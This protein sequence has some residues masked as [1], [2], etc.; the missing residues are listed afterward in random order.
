MNR[1]YV[2]VAI[3]LLALVGCRSETST[4]TSGIRPTVNDQATR[5]TLFEQTIDNLNHAEEFET[6]E[7][8]H[9]IV[10]RLNQW[11]G[12]QK[13]DAKWQLDPLAEPLM[14][15]L[16][17]YA[18][19]ARAVSIAM[20]KPRNDLELRGLAAELQ[21]PMQALG[22]LVQ[23]RP[24]DE[25][26]GLEREFSD[27]FSRVEQ[28]MK[29]FS[30][31][32]QLKQAETQ[33]IDD[34]A[35]ELKERAKIERFQGALML[36]QPLDYP[37]RFRDA[38]AINSLA[39]QVAAVAGQ[40]DAQ[41]REQ[42][43]AKF[44]DL[45]GRRLGSQVKTKTALQLEF[46]V[47]LMRESDKLKDL[48]ELRAITARLESLAQQLR[49]AAQRTGRKDLLELLPPFES[50]RKK[51]DLE[52]LGS[53]VGKILAI[54]QPEG[55]GNLKSYGVE[56]YEPAKK[57]GEI[58]SGMQQYAKKAD[59]QALAALG[60]KIEKLSERMQELGREMEAPQASDEPKKQQARVQNQLV[61][62]VAAITEIEFL[63]DRLASFTAL[64]SLE[65]TFSD[66]L[67]LQEAVILRDL[68]QWTRG[69][70][71]GDVAY[72]GRL[73]DWTVRNIQPDD[74]GGNR[75]MQLSMETLLLGRGTA[76]DRTWIFLLLARQQ[77]LDAAVLAIADP[78]DPLH[79]RVLPWAIGVLSE[80]EI[81]LFDPGLGIPIPGPD[82]V[83]LGKSGALE[84]R[85]ATLAQVIADDSLLRKLDRTGRPYPV[86]AKQLERVVALVEA[87]P[88]YLA[89]RMDVLEA[90]LV[91]DQ[92]MVLSASPSELAG[93]LKQ[94]KQVSD[95]RLWTMP[96]EALLQRATI[97]PQIAQWQSAMMAPFQ[98]PS[99]VRKPSGKQAS[100]EP[101]ALLFIQDEQ[102]M[103]QATGGHTLK[104]E[105]AEPSS[106][107]PL[108]RGRT[109]HL[110]G[111]FTAEPG[112]P[113]AT[114]AYLEARP[115]DRRLNEFGELAKKSGQA[116]LVALYQAARQDASYWLGLMAYEQNS[117]ASATD[118]L[119]KYTLKAYPNG[120]WTPGATYNLARVYEAEKNY[121]EA[122]KLYRQKIALAAY[123][124]GELRSK[125]LAELAKIDLPEEKPE[126]KPKAEKPDADLP[127]LPSLPALPG[128]SEKKQ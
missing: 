82:G 27:M 90:G 31:A 115:S 61:Q 41:E 120:P 5:D 111:R 50:A 45:V 123:P 88:S 122:I 54:A 119:A 103:K 97:G 94:C 60:G 101:V 89:R 100:E 56:L 69:D 98:T 3:L 48:A 8:L 30:D 110:K 37:A 39:Q 118:Y 9:Q 58:A 34:F 102:Q 49:N 75:P 124:G 105:E 11:I 109:M 42:M 93:R 59:F 55:I 116:G 77:G 38:A 52:Q 32:D 87:S 57:L 76:M 70:E 16:S 21:G 14:K 114:R 106:V 51:L 7:M 12:G 36:I 79:E 71:P 67:A 33:L 63:A 74:E 35:T 24:L 81:Y 125:W 1:I 113:S 92:Q 91:G 17:S 65:F 28:S 126:P 29:L 2:V 53:T 19:Q 4:K 128:L 73:F 104:E 44:S 99:L 25:L 95:V 127:D 84:I 66:H 20:Q 107:P 23:R 80:G 117:L 64:D 18:E 40:W 108:L 86:G 26:T 15:E 83:K 72:A 46:L 47:R 112:Q 43:A 68:S 78:R 121:A 13:V 6:N 96:Y 62:F 10:D 22:A 85:P